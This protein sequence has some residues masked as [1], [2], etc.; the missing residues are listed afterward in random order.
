MYVWRTTET[1]LL[2]WPNIR[3]CVRKGLR[4]RPLEKQGG[5]RGGSRSFCYVTFF[6]FAVCACFFFFYLF[7]SFLSLL[8]LCCS[9]CFLLFHALLF[10]FVCLFLYGFILFRYKSVCK[11]FL[12][13]PI[14]A[15]VG[16]VAKVTAEPWSNSSWYVPCIIYKV[17]V[18]TKEITGWTVRQCT[19]FQVKS[20][21]LEF[22]SISFKPN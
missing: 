1:S 9:G 10:L 4:L 5:R 17:L 19:V 14:V 13:C 20:N 21:S 2:E 15:G 22:G 8:F 11:F 16:S 6:G 7:F 18:L 3:A 12:W